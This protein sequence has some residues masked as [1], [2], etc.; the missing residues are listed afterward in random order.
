M[1]SDLLVKLSPSPP[2]PRKRQIEMSQ[3]QQSLSSA[4]VS[5]E[6]YEEETA[7]KR[8]RQLQSPALTRR[9]RQNPRKLEIFQPSSKEQEKHTT[10]TRSYE[11]DRRRSSSENVK[12]ARRD[13]IEIG[14]EYL[15][16]LDDLTDEYERLKRQKKSLDNQSN[17]ETKESYQRT[18]EF[19]R[20]QPMQ[21]ESS[22]KRSS[23]EGLLHKRL[24]PITTLDMTLSDEDIF[25]MEY[26]LK[27]K[28]R[29]KPIRIH[30][31]SNSIPGETSIKYVSTERKPVEV[32]VPK[33]QII[34]TQGE[35]SS[36]VVKDTR[37]SSRKVTTTNIHQQPRRRTI[38]GQHELRI[39]E[40]PI[41]CDRTRTVEF[42]IQKPMPT[43]HT[44][45][46]MVHS[47]KGGRFN[48]VDISQT[49]ARERTLSG[50]HEI[51][52][53]SK[54]IRSSSHNKPLEIVFPKPVFSSSSSSSHSSTVVKQNR[55]PKSSIY[56]DNIQ[57][58]IKGEHELR[59]IDKPIQSGPANSVELIVPKSV[60]DT[61]EHTTTVITE[62]QPHR[63]VL[64][65]TGSGKQM[66]SEHERK[67]FHDKVRV[68]EEIEVKIPKQKYEQVEHSTT[69][70][71]HSR[72]KGPI[73]EI[74]T[75]R[76]PI[77]GEHET[78]IIEKAVETVADA[79]Q[80]LI[81]KPQIPA[82]HS[83][84]IIKGQRGKPQIFAVDQTQ[85]IPGMSFFFFISF[86]SYFHF[87][88][89]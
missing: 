11:Y 28:E 27:R 4:L 1:L 74:D 32:L 2:L 5:T 87:L 43:E 35:H 6:T 17:Y 84:T 15:R 9:V 68:E 31:S 24:Q 22:Y 70:V 16:C 77:Q 89:N 76:R 34:T 8:S 7:F 18:E 30:S 45:T 49:L 39:I 51:R 54:P 20:S 52:V 44:S 19:Y 21:I 10:I 53:I 67:Y 62:T 37:R 25:S 85:P 57:R 38:E 78:K 26:R 71:K 3:Q 14:R 64:E 13:N 83:T 75:S 41:I 80:L 40:Q 46:Y 72:G 79:M 23:S 42:T 66:T 82:E 61:A 88:L 47:R 58:T 56:L 69:L 63:R 86:A 81:A 29:L 60:T 55:T 48:T 36:T 50:E 65:I 12:Q 73:I 59:L 33:P